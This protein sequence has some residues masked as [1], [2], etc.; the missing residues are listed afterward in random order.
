MAFRWYDESGQLR[1]DEPDRS[2]CIGTRHGTYPAYQHAGCRCPDAREAWRLYY[3]KHRH[4]LLSPAWVEST[5]ARRRVRALMRVGFTSWD[6]TRAA[7]NAGFLVSRY[8]VV[9]LAMSRNS[10]IS[11]TTHNAVKAAYDSL[12][13]LFGESVTNI[14]CSR[15]KGWPSPLAWEGVDID[16]PNKKP[17]G[18]RALNESDDWDWV[19]VERA[20][21]GQL[22]WSQ[23]NDSERVRTVT[24][25]LDANAS[26]TS[27]MTTLKINGITADLFIKRARLG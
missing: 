7:V 21:K 18:L 9:P 15:R 11:A 24:E 22:A 8:T 27:I 2:A 4:K 1:T 25:L 23:L 13:G 16:D 12:S 5:G 3:F 6:I 20:K 19:I 26:K 17:Q 14:A 10:R